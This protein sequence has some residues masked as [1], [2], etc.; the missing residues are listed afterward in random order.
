MNCSIN[1]LYAEGCNTTSGVCQKGCRAGW[2]GLKCDT[3][4]EDGVYGIGCKQKC[5]AFCSV[6]GICDHETGAC[7]EGCKSGWVGMD[8]LQ[9]KENVEG[10]LALYIFVGAFSIAVTVIVILIIYI[11][12]LRGRIGQFHTID[13]YNT[14]KNLSMEAEG[15]NYDAIINTSNNEYQELGVIGQ[16]IPRY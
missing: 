8:C 7:K 1:C 10:K 2:K 4:C 3:P 12:R 14:S 13:K 9:V 5:S 16:N 11:I 15:E 6:S